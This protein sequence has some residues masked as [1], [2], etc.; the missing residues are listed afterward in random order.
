MSQQAPP[1]PVS[2]AR[3]Y[4][5]RYTV[6]KK[7]Q[8]I[9]KAINEDAQWSLAEF[10]H[11]TFAF[12]DADNKKI[13]RTPGHTTSVTRF[14]TGSTQ[15]TVPHIIDLWMRASAGRPRTSEDHED[16]FSPTKPFLEIKRAQPAITTFAYQL[17][18]QRMVSQRTKATRTSAASAAT[19]KKLIWEDV[20]ATTVQDITEQLKADQDLLWDLAMTL[21]TPKPRK[22]NGEV[23]ETRTNRPPEIVS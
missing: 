14:L 6:A 13:K 4:R 16:M 5:G 2:T 3:A 21:A 22:R 19:D 18:R 7:L 20:S 10:L 15:Y 17:T 8:I 12:K 23:V 9:F 1:T 11:Y